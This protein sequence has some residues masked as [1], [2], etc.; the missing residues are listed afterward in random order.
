MGGNARKSPSRLR[1]GSGVG[2]LP[3]SM[4]SHPLPLPQAGGE[5]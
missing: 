1:E 4:H 5:K 3:S 2:K